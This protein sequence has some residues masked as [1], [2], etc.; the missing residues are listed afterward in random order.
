MSKLAIVKITDRQFLPQAYP[1]AYRI[2]I[3]KKLL[4]FKSIKMD[5]LYVRHLT[6]GRNQ[7]KT[8]MTIER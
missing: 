6:T 8:I 3:L 1:I 7:A 2:A 4:S 5:T